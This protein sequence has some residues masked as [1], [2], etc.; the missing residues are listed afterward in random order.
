MAIELKQQFYNLR[1]AWAVKGGCAWNTFRCSRFLQPKGG[2]YDGY[3]GGR[4]VF[5][6]E[7]IR[8]WLP[9]ADSDLEAYHDKYLTG[10]KPANRIKTARPR[11]AGG[12]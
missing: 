8:E 9:L 3:Y 7:T 4:G 5:S 11:A 2:H 10:A 6:A 1:D 12:V